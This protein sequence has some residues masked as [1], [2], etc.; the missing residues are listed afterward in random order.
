[1]QLH[2]SWWFYGVCSQLK[3]LDTGE[4]QPL[5]G[6]EGGGGSACSED[7]ADAPE[8]AR[9]D[10]EERHLMQSIASAFPH[11][12]SPLKVR[13]RCWEL[14]R[15]EGVVSLQ[16]RGGVLRVPHASDRAARCRY[17]FLERNTA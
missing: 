5:A 11:R 14:W 10:E 16:C 12:G 9:H 13:L 15:C 3:N 7:E 17:C 8:D 2:Y 1:V 4:V 6:P